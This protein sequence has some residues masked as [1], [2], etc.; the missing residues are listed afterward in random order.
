MQQKIKKIITILLT[1][2]YI[3]LVTACQRNIIIDSSGMDGSSEDN[4]PDNSFSEESQESG[5]MYE[6][7]MKN[8]M[9]KDYIYMWWPDNVLN[10]EGLLKFQGPEY[11]LE[12]DTERGIISNLSNIKYDERYFKIW[13][14]SVLGETDG[15]ISVEHSGNTYTAGNSSNIELGR[16][17]ARVLEGGRYVQRADVLTIP[18]QGTDTFFSRIEIAAL[19]RYFV[20]TYDLYSKESLQ[21]VT[22]KYELQLPE[23]YTI[24]EKADEDRIVNVRNSSGE[25]FTF[26][27]N[28]NNNNKTKIR[29]DD[30]K[31]IA[32][33]E[34][35]TLHPNFFSGF[36]IIVIPSNKSGLNDA[37]SIRLPRDFTIQA[38]QISPNNRRQIS[39]YNEQYGIFEISLADAHTKQ[40]EDFIDEVVRNTYDR[41]EFTITN[42]SSKSIKVPIVF[43]KLPPFSMTGVTPIIRDIETKEP[44]GVQVQISKNWHVHRGISFNDPRRHWEGS[45]LNAYVELE[46][47]ANKS[48][49][50]EYTAPFA[51]WGGVESVSHAQL[52]LVGW[53]GNNLWDQAALGSYGESI[54][55]RPETY[56]FIADVRPLFVKSVVGGYRKF[57]WGGNV[58]GGDFLIVTTQQKLHDLFGVRTNY[59]SQGPNLTNVSYQAYSAEDKIKIDYNVR[60]GRTNDVVRNYFTLRYE[61]LD[62]VSIRNIK[63]FSMGSTTYKLTGHRK[64]AYGNQDG[65]IDDFEYEE[66]TLSYYDS[67]NPQKLEMP[68]ENFWFIAYDSP[69]EEENASTM[70]IVRDFVGKINGVDYTSPAFNIKQLKTS[71][72]KQISFEITTPAE[73]GDIIKKGSVMEMQIEYICLPASEEAYYGESEYLNQTKNLFNTYEAALQQVKYG[74]VSAAAIVGELEGSFPVTV[75]VDNENEILA[76]LSLTGGLGYTP[77]VFKGVKGYS[78]YSLEKKVGDAW[79]K[80][81]QSIHGNDFWQTNFD[82]A[83]GGYTFVYNVKNTQGTD[84]N[85]T[86]EYRLVK[87][88]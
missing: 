24:V 21:D 77:V 49:S 11:F 44:I 20:I 64:Y 62:D 32:T 65:L 7:D 80:V 8:Q 60:L 43:Q 26:V 46:V 48:I 83:S 35:K 76:H 66:N 17:K 33:C 54:T 16:S 12:L 67:Q 4:N 59:I 81:D 51:T 85:K 14:S 31:I 82:Y 3:L 84:Y 88:S 37:D 39:R 87:K 6:V 57:D 9:E 40:G 55:F 36:S 30:G 27:V 45:W 73:A 1:L 52:S 15:N 58:G 70:F 72:S 38:N 2:I 47:P 41:V 25:G 28:D 71:P 23:G 50:Y 69:V 78:G 5:Q 18:F 34:R 10:T 61:F 56:S 13:E 19:Q 22:Y 79:E 74:I 63:L 86:N 42:N 75:K 53:G 68:G 29:F